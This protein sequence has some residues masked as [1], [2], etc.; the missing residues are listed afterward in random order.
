MSFFRRHFNRREE[1]PLHQAGVKGELAK[2]E[3]VAAHQV[4]WKTTFSSLFKV[5]G[6]V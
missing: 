4:Y 5:S 6:L 1:M 3:E 2:K